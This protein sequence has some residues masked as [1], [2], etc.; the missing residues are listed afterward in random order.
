MSGF[1][2]QGQGHGRARGSFERVVTVGEGLAVFRSGPDEPL[3]PAAPVAVGT[4]GAEANVA[5]TLAHPGVPVVRAGRA[6][7]DPPARRIVRE[8]RAGGVT[9]RTVVDPDRPTGLLVKDVR[10]DGRTAV[11]YHRAGSAGSAL[12][13]ADVD[14]LDLDL[15]PG[16][17]VHVTG[18]TGCLSDSAAESVRHLVTRAR[19]AGALVSFDVNHRPRL[20]GDRPAAEAH[21]ELAEAADLVV[22][23]VDE[24][25]LLVGSAVGVDTRAPGLEPAELA[26]D[27][28][29]G[30]GHRPGVV[31]AGA[32]GACAGDGGD[33]AP[34]VAHEI[35]GVDTV[36]AGDAFVGG[37]LAGWARGE[38]LTGRLRLASLSG[39]AA[40]RHAGDWEGA[41]D[42]DGLGEGP[43]SGG[44]PVI[45]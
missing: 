2:G 23:S 40:C 19:E 22:A 10:T 39:A 25:P 28:W 30:A 31:A 18:I 27:A 20:W 17:L 9:V 26:A 6:A 35:D 36:G 8:L 4:G 13:A 1:Q 33:R 14:A 16:T 3:W 29:V 5:M 41:V 38:V 37:Y 44:D 43:G 42:P 15:A 34:V 11:S 45:R 21:R 24:V 12:T 32:A 7:A